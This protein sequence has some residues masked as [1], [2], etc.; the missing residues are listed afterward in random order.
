MV[1]LDIFYG[2]DPMDTQK[3]NMFIMTN[4]KIF[5]HR[6]RLCNLKGEVKGYR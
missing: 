2:G 5:S 4:Q 1:E 6:K 3:L